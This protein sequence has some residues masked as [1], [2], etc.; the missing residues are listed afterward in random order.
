MLTEPVSKRRTGNADSGNKD[1]LVLQSHTVALAGR[2]LPSGK[3]SDHRR[4]LSV[5]ECN[6][7]A[8]SGLVKSGILAQ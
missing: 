1:R 6:L 7:R 5:R 2:V 4:I 8:D 3:G